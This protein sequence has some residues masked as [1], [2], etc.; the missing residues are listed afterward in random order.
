MLIPCFPSLFSWDSSFLPL[1]A[2]S[3]LIAFGKNIRASRGSIDVL[4]QVDV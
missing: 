2:F 1:F 3:R 4:F